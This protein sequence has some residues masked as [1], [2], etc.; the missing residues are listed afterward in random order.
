MH[1]PV[2]R[3]TRGSPSETDKAGWSATKLA[4]PHFRFDSWPWQFTGRIFSPT[5][6]S[7][8]FAAENCRFYLFTAISIVAE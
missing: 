4:N 3:A 1:R 8:L 7:G 2:R 5:V 6:S